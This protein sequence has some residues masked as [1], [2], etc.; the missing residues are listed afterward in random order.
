MTKAVVSAIVIGL[1]T[2]GLRANTGFFR[3]SGHTIA[4][5]KTEQVQMVSEDVAIYP[6]CSWTPGMDWVDYRCRFVLKNLVAKPL[7]IQVGFPLDREF[8]EG[9]RIALIASTDLVLG[10]NFVARE[11]K[12]TYHVRFV[13]NDSE[14]RFSRLFVWDIPFDAR[15]I[16]TVHVAYRLPISVALH[17]TRKD[18]ATLKGSPRYERRWHEVLEHCYV[19]QFHYV[20]ETGSSW[21]GR[22]EKA[23]FRVE[24]ESLARCMKDRPVSDTDPPEPQGERE[25]AAFQ[26][27]FPMRTGAFYQMIEPR[28][29]KYDA[30]WGITTWEHKDYKPSDS[31]HLSYYILAFPRTAEDCDTWVRRLLGSKPA[32]ADLTELR[33][34][35]AAFYGIAPQ[36]KS[37]KA[38]VERQIWYHPKEGLRES[39]L[40]EEQRSVLKR[41]DAII[42][43]H[44]AQAQDGRRVQD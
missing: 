35:V 38:F 24:T 21:A 5:A 15:E 39:D 13:H 41:L 4:L 19:E 40:G 3:G 28:G 16:K 43:A 30:T 11:D 25:G 18:F 27:S 1:F 42:E 2:S 12:A 29:W 37:G 14:Q 6:A 32:K 36:S 17:S 23:V 26:G 8:R 10:Y 33:E 31:L 22:I 44:G 20:T 7:T 34:I 9:H